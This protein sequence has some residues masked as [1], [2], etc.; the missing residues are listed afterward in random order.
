MAQPLQFTCNYLGY[1]SCRVSFA[2]C[3]A[4][5]TVF[6]TTMSMCLNLRPQYFNMGSELL[7]NHASK[8]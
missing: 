1:L 3:C 2:K 4:Q 7:V 8:L 6:A 5:H